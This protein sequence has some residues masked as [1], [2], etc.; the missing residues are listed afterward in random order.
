MFS[1]DSLQ[2][3]PLVA[4]VDQ[5]ICNSCFFCRTVCPYNAIEE[6]ERAQRLGGSM[7]VQVIAQVNQGKCTGCG[8]CAA[9]CPSK[10]VTVEGFTEQQIYEEVMHAI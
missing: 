5:S 4:V 6:F 8:L 7:S 10:A 1:R 9:A 3:E 2:R